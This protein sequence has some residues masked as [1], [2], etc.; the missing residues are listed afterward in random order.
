MTSNVETLLIV[1]NN[2][3]DVSLDLITKS[4]EVPERYNCGKISNGD[5]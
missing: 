2:D 1:G 3:T 4:A 5:S